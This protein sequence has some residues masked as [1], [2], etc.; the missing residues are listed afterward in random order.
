MSQKDT[1]LEKDVLDNFNT[2]LNKLKEL[3]CGIKEIELS[4]MEYSLPVYY[5]IMPAEVSSNLARFDGMRYGLRTEGEDLFADYAYTRGK[6][7]GAEVRRRILLGTYVLSAGYHDAYYKKAVSVQNVIRKECENV[8]ED[9]DI[10]A[11]PTSPTPAFKLGERVSDP[12]S[13]YL[14]DVL[15]VFA[16]ISGFPAIS[17]PSGTVERDGKSLPLGLQFTASHFREN[18]LFDAGKKFET[19]QGM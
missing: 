17:I 1:P 11:T 13:M 16:N 6:G 7:F 4:S 8:F 12:V 15:T 2:S 19:A 9:V 18:V 5:I 14:S 3:G 10:I